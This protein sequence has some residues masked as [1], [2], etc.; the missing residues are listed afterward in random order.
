MPQ[1]STNTRERMRVN[2]REPKKYK[3]IMHNDD[4]TEMEFVIKVLM[5]VFFKPFDEAESIMLEIHNN[6]QAI[7]GI[8]SYDIANT[9]VLKVK[10]M[11]DAEKFP[12][13]LTIEPAS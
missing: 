10:R 5:E 3:V 2:T 13:K 12:L 11:A 4:V 7:V 8:Y 1:E 6:G 9:K